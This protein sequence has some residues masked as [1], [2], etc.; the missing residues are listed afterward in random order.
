M[1]DTKDQVRR[2]MTR[3]GLDR[4]ECWSETLGRVGRFFP[5]GALSEGG[6][7]RWFWREREKRRKGV[8]GQSYN[9]TKS[10]GGLDGEAP[11]PFPQWRCTHKWLGCVLAPPSRG[12][13]SANPHEAMIAR[14]LA[15]GRTLLSLPLVPMLRECYERHLHTC[16]PTP[17]QNRWSDSS[18]SVYRLVAVVA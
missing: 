7:G 11:L 12:G 5:F 18:S 13:I 6:G 10:G 15:G 9:S 2:E 16:V 1:N 17:P 14:T 8:I 3:G 4:S